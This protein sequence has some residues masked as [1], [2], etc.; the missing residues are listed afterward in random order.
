MPTQQYTAQDV[1]DLINAYTLQELQAKLRF[2]LDM[3]AAGVSSDTYQGNAVNFR[4]IE[5]LTS[6]IRLHS[7]AVTSITTNTPPVGSMRGFRVL[8]GYGL[9]REGYYR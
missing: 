3:R 7:A 6:V 5:D 8:D 9:R 4:T 1:Q 2:L